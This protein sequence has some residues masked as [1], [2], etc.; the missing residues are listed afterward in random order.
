[1][2]KCKNTVLS[3][4]ERR[5]PCPQPSTLPT[6]VLTRA[7]TERTQCPHL[8]SLH[9]HSR[10]T[11]TLIIIGTHPNRAPYTTQLGLAPP[12]DSVNLT[13]TGFTV[14]PC[15]RYFPSPMATRHVI[16]C[17]SPRFLTCACLCPARHS[18][19]A[20]CIA[21]SQASTM[22]ISTAPTSIATK[23][24]P[25]RYTNSTEKRPCFP[26]CTL[27]RPQASLYYGRNGR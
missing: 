17:S 11:F 22:S 12:N 16:P 15:D 24:T 10:S 3:W 18:T 26:P 23:I 4:L 25:A 7:T 13:P 1:M 14:F 2:R 19:I 6:P 27:R 8:R 5:I 21:R 20:N 9:A